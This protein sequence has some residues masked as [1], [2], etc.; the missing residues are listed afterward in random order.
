[1]Q[2]K[3]YMNIPYTRLR[4]H[5]SP[6]DYIFTHTEVSLNFENGDTFGWLTHQL[7]R[8]RLPMWLS[9]GLE[10]HVKGQLG[11]FVPTNHN[12]AKGTHFSDLSFMPGT[13][14]TAERAAAIDMAYNFISNLAKMGLLA[15]L[16]ALYQDGETQQ[17]N[18]KAENHFYN[19]FGWHIN[20]SATWGFASFVNAYV[21]TS[22]STWATAEIAIRYLSTTLSA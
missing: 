3:A 9:V 20:T 15:E 18:Y 2:L 13:W 14:R 6:Y 11:I 10:A 5:S 16:V 21:I 12:F 7:S 1:M 4:I 19:H 8:G 17:A 22:Q